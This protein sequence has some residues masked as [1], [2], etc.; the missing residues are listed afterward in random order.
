MKCHICSAEKET[1]NERVPR[2]WKRAKGEIWCEKCWNRAYILRAVTIPVVGPMDKVEWPAFRE[3]LKSAWAAST[4]LANWANDENYTRDIRRNGEAKCPPQP[5]TYLYPEARVAFPSLPS[6]TVAAVLQSVAG[7]YRAT[8]YETVWTRERALATHRYPSPFVA[9]NQGWSAEIIEQRPVVHV[10]IGDRRWSI[11]LRGGQEFRRQLG[12]IR[13]I[14]SGEAIQ[15]ELAIMR[16]RAKEADHRNG[17]TQSGAQWRIMMKIVGWF[18]RKEQKEKSGVLRI[19]TGAE[20][21][22]IAVDEKDERLWAENAD[23]VRRWIAEYDRQRQRWSEDMKAEQRP[24]PS[25]VARRDAATQKQRDRMKSAIDEITSHVAKFSE[26]RRFSEVHYDDT[27]RSFA[28]SFPWYIFQET[29]LRKL[30]DRGIKFIAS[31]PVVK[32]TPE[33]AREDV[34]HV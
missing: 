26:R 8:R 22:I 34:S 15:G 12:D 28:S 27:D 13:Q 2:G 29:L 18:P 31:A 32:P 21:L 4:G 11:V 1:K 24:V 16:A 20:S 7:K 19:R 10:R 17:V 23:H 6:Q 33:D 25:F 30:E 3:A 14:V 5:K 9:P